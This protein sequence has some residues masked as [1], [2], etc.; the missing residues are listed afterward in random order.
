MT[1]RESR[2]RASRAEQQAKRARFAEPERRGGTNVASLVALA[3]GVALVFAGL[4]VMAG[5]GRSPTAG[6]GGAVAQP[7]SA[8]AVRRAGANFVMVSPTEGKIRLPIADFADG[9]ARFYTLRDGGKDIDFFVVKSSDGVLRTAVDSCDVCYAARKGY[10]QEGDEMVCNNCGQRFP[11][12]KIN[13]V[14]GGCNPVPLDRSVEGSDLIILQ[15]DL[16]E[17]GGRYF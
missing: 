11:S 16:V 9:K 7:G 5:V 17:D 13:E 8:D 2:P 10:R 15:R 4:I 12:A 1:D 6:T 14:R 3:A